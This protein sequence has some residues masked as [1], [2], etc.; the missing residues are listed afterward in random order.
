MCGF[1]VCVVCVRLF[2]CVD[3][4]I[5]VL[6]EMFP[7]FCVIVSVSVCWIVCDC[8]LC[9]VFVNLFACVCVCV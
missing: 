7:N 1:R 4:C 8:L 9:Y 5:Y 6:C 3:A 2:L